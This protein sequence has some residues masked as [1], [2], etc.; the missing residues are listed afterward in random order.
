MYPNDDY[1]TRSSLRDDGTHLNFDD[2]W[3]K[4]KVQALSTPG[5]PK[6]FITRR[7]LV[8][9]KIRSTPTLK[10]VW[11]LRKIKKNCINLMLIFNAKNS[12]VLINFSLFPKGK[13]RYVDGKIWQFYP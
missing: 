6:I 5:V 12:I 9:K 1:S 10:D 2:T 4:R 3:L 13:R 11:L 8:L 7:T